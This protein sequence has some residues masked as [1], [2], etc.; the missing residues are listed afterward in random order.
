MQSPFWALQKS[1][2]KCVAEKQKNGDVRS[3]LRNATWQSNVLMHCFRQRKLVSSSQ[4]FL[5]INIFFFIGLISMSSYEKNL[6]TTKYINF[7]CDFQK[8]LLWITNICQFIFDV[9][10]RRKSWNILLNR[11]LEQILSSLMYNFHE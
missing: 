9:Q 4:L 6:S 2:G 10:C 8:N 1:S 11:N 7:Q 3:S 5:K